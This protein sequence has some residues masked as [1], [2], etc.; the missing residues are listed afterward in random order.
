MRP[1]HALHRKND[2]SGRGRFEVPRK[3]LQSTSQADQR[4]GEAAAFSPQRLNENLTMRASSRRL[5]RL[6]ATPRSR[7]SSVRSE[8]GLNSWLLIRNLWSVNHQRS[9]SQWIRTMM[10]R[11]LVLLSGGIDSAACAHFL[12]KTFRVDGLFVDFGQGALAQERIA[13]RAVAAALAIGWSEASLRLE[14]RFG[15]GEI[16]GRNALLLTLAAAAKPTGTSIIAMGIHAGTPYYDCS[17]AFAEK[18]DALLQEQSGG[19]LRF[20]APFLTWSKAEIYEYCRQEGLDLSSTY[21]CEAGGDSPCGCC[22]SCQDRL[23]LNAGE[24]A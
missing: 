18:V 4:A 10:Q 6:P 1:V 13:S 21:S 9:R 11:A 23:R 12:Q 19:D 22:L 3:G 15:S 5:S 16:P 20:L 24:T 7:A 17:P 14:K 8:I 2:A